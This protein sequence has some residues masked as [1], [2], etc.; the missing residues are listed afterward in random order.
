MAK[1]VVSDIEWDAEPEEIEDCNLPYETIMETDDPDVIAEVKD[2]G[3]AQA[4][5]D[6]LSDTYEFCVYSFSAWVEED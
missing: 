3:Y 2:E 5:E 4:V 1:I 6:W